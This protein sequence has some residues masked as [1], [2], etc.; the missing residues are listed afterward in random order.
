MNRQTYKRL[1]HELRLINRSI[2][3]SNRDFEMAD[4]RLMMQHTSIA[5]SIVRLR[6]HIAALKRQIPVCRDPNGFQIME[7]NWARR[8]SHVLARM[9]R[10]AMIAR[11]D[12]KYARAHD[13][14]FAHQKAMRQAA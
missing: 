14:Y 9:K 13:A 8:R 10:D 12:T 2:T 6:A 11:D 7:Q 5:E 4:S 1:R 3:G